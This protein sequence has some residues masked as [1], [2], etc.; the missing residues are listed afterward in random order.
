MTDNRRRMKDLVFLFDAEPATHQLRLDLEVVID[1]FNEDEL[2]VFAKLVDAI[3]AALRFTTELRRGDTITVTTGTLLAFAAVAERILAKRLDQG[4]LSLTSSAYS[5]TDE[6]NLANAT[7]ILSSSC[8][9]LVNQ[10]QSL[11]DVPWRLDT[12]QAAL[13]SELGRS[14]TKKT[15][16]RLRYLVDSIKE[17]EAPKPVEPPSKDCP[18]SLKAFPTSCVVD[19][20]VRCATVIELRCPQCEVRWQPSDPELQGQVLVPRHEPNRGWKLGER[21]VEA[22]DKLETPKP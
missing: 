16:A 15:P 21:I 4:A 9:A 22:L 3:L 20:R 13:L 5:Y 18:A 6:A 14:I 2:A 12:M 7:A 19:V 8:R 1:L 11:S 17:Q 10:R